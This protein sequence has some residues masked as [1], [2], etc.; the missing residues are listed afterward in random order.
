MTTWEY[1]SQFSMENPPNINLQ[2]SIKIQKEYDNYLASSK[3]TTIHLLDL[4]FKNSEDM[5]LRKNDFPYNCES[6]IIH[7][8]LWINPNYNIT[9][10]DIK[11]YINSLDK[12]VIYF[13]NIDKYKSVKSIRHV[14]VFIQ[15]DN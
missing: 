6:S 3:N 11:K 12:K 9:N 2:R 10:P 13:E 15:E 8:V 5:V 4:I 14:H 1:L 7:M